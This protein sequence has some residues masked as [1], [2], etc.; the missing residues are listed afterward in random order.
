MATVNDI[1]SKTKL[2]KDKED[3]ILK[4]L[5]PEKEMSLNPGSD[6]TNNLLSAFSNIPYDKIDEENEIDPLGNIA[7]MPNIPINNGNSIVDDVLQRSTNKFNFDFGNNTVAS[8]ANPAS[9]AT[10]D[11]EYAT[12]MDE[13][14]AI[15]AKDR[16]KVGFMNTMKTIDSASSLLNNLT[17]GDGITPIE[18]AHLVSPEA[19]YD[20]TLRRAV[21]GEA[22]KSGQIAQS[23][24]MKLGM[25]GLIP[26]IQ[27]NALKATNEANTQ[28]QAQLN[29]IQQ[30]NAMMG[31]QTAN[32]EQQLYI[33]QRDKIIQD[34]LQKNNMRYQA[35]GQSK[36]ALWKDINRGM[37]QNQLYKDADIQTKVYEYMKKYP[38]A[39]A[40]AIL[41]LIGADNYETKKSKSSSKSENEFEIN[42]KKYKQ[43][44]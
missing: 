26:A 32:N 14:K 2:N 1:L 20:D 18:G 8:S 33:Q 37:E 28:A 13:I 3:K 12:L 16:K 17:E 34:A 15:N 22:M 4:S 44:D 21:A 24:A 6:I 19:K 7:P 36:D 27:N 41:A 38:G 29:Q 31:A 10:S 25:G 35:I 43:V 5:F 9:T 11:N 30:Q 39:D 42:G 23:N 40:D